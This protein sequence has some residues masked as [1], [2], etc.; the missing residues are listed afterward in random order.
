[1]RVLKSGVTLFDNNLD[2][3]ITIRDIS[4]NVCDCRVME[5]D[6]EMNEV[7][8]TA[9]FTTSELKTSRYTVM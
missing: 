7:H 8:Y 3:Y 4:N 5:Y 2:R 9:L 1:M 6:E